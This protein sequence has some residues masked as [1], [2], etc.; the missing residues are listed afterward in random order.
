M[1]LYH[2]AIPREAILEA[3]EKVDMTEEDWQRQERAFGLLRRVYEQRTKIRG[4]QVQVLPIPPPWTSEEYDD[5]NDPM[6]HFR[7]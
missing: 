5:G 2:A 6:A 7:A 3:C 4:Q 1:P